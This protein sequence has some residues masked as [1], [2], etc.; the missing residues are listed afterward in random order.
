MLLW[1]G[2]VLAE[3]GADNVSADDLKQQAAQARNQS[4]YG[5]AAALLEQAVQMNGT[6]EMWNQL[7]GVYY[8]LG[9][10][11][12]AREAFQTAVEIDPNYTLAIVNLEAVLAEEERAGNASAD[13]LKQQAAQARNQSDYGKAAA[14]LEQAVQKSGTA[15]MW[16]LLGEAYYELE[17]YVEAHE[18]YQT[19][20]EID[21]N[22]TRAIANLEMVK[23]ALPQPG[24]EDSMQQRFSTPKTIGAQILG[25]YFTGTAMGGWFLFISTLMGY[26]ELDDQMTIMASALV[27]SSMMRVPEVGK[28][29]SFGH[30]ASR[31]A[32]A[33]AV[34]PPLIGA[35]VVQLSNENP[36]RR[37]LIHGAR[38]GAIFS[39]LASTLGYHI[40]T[41]RLLRGSS[42]TAQY[43]PFERT[44]T[45][46]S[47]QFAQFSF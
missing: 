1:A 13:D 30:G 7:G 14:L 6:A 29:V 18:A 34:L 19:A 44:E 36:S 41:S 38:I 25:S 11:I 2:A 35:L 31:S 26:K 42:S 9:R 4:D 46:L 5:K 24:F 37:D 27:L 22:Y 16:N 23:W 45:Q 47:F 39:P 12:E 8:E 17:R 21:P 20:L 3:E 33:G 10:Y 32:L 15:E 28:L 43:T 40:S